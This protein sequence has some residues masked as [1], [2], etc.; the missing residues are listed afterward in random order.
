MEKCELWKNPLPPERFGKIDKWKN[1]NGEKL[2]SL[3]LFII[4]TYP[5]L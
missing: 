5:Y 1:V 4:R 3:L 2:M